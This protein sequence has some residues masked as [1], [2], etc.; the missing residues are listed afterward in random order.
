MEENTKNYELINNI[1]DNR[2]APTKIEGPQTH[3]EE[4]TQYTED[5]QTEYTEETQQPETLLK[6]IKIYYNDRIT[7]RLYSKRSIYH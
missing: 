4:Q 1:L 5:Q 7:F 6:I 2:Q 3:T